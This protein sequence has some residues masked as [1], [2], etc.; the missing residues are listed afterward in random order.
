MGQ[1]R[2]AGVE[3]LVL[4]QRVVADLHEVDNPRASEG[5]DRLE[6]VREEH[7][8]D[9]RHA[10]LVRRIQPPPHVAR[11]PGPFAHREVQPRIELVRVDEAF[12]EMHH[13]AADV[14]RRPGRVI[15]DRAGILLLP[16]VQKLV[17]QVAAAAEIPVERG[18]RD[19]Q[20]V[21][22]GQNLDLAHPVLDQHLGR[23]RQPILAGDLY[24]AFRRLVG[25]G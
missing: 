11:A 17:Q 6:P 16:L 9:R 25:R 23:Q 4:D 12:E 8:A 14:A 21:G 3:G 5:L 1:H 7:V 19:P 22:Q 15:E 13:R 18:S 20:L 24:V 2:E 10:G